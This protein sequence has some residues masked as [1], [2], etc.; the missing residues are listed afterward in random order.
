MISDTINCQTAQ[1]HNAGIA[2]DC[3]SDCHAVLVIAWNDFADRI[4]VDGNGSIDGEGTKNI[5]RGHRGDSTKIARV[6]DCDLSAWIGH[7]Y[8]VSESPARRSANTGIVIGTNTG[9]PGLWV[10]RMSR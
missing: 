3:H 4:T 10:L 8:R 2:W 7:R 6:Q 5:D 1:D 9:H